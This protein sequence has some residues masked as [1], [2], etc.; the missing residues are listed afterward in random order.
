[1]SG[2]EP[3]AQGL[4]LVGDAFGGEEIQKLNRND[5][6]ISQTVCLT[7]VSQQDTDLLLGAAPF[8]LKE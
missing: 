6:E 2:R 4:D 7:S 5:S 8:E 3:G 1:M